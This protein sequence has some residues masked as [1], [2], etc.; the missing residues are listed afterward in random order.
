MNSSLLSSSSILITP[1]PS[2]KVEPGLLEPVSLP[3][4][5]NLGTSKFSLLDSFVF[6]IEVRAN[7]VRLSNS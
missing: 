1:P 3:G 7:A 5:N 6:T 4:N 2:L